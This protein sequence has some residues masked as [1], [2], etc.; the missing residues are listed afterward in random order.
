MANPVAYEV[1]H[2]DGA[3][4]VDLIGPGGTAIATQAPRL[5][6]DT[7]RFA[8]REPEEGV[9]LRCALGRDG[10]RGF[11]GRC[12]DNGGQWARFTMVPPGL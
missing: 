5:E 11:A 12:T 4:A 10:E 2:E 7:L 3:L 8:F 6:G 9:R 1:R